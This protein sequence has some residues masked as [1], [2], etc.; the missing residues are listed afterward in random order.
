MRKGNGTA[1]VRA[2]MRA[3][4]LKTAVVAVA[5]RRPAFSPAGEAKKA[6]R[7]LRPPGDLTV[8]TVNPPSGAV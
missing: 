5:S 3:A 2:A 7:Q 6:S 4:T 8:A 1:A